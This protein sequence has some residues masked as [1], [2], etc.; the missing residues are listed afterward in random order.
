VGRKII[1]LVQAK[2]CLFDLKSAL[3]SDNVCSLQLLYMQA[4][5]ELCGRHAKCLLVFQ[6]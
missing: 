5:I 2:D 6:G 1:S 3:V 4:S